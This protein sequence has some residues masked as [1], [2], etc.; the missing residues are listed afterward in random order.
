MEAKKAENRQGTLKSTG[1]YLLTSCD[2]SGA[3]HLAASENVI[4]FQIGKGQQLIESFSLAADDFPH[5]MRS[6]EKILAA[7]ACIDLF[8]H[9][10]ILL[11]LSTYY[12]KAEL[13]SHGSESDPTHEAPIRVQPPSLSR[14]TQPSSQAQPSPRFPQ[15]TPSSIQFPD[16]SPIQNT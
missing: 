1:C 4:S 10:Q 12:H 9:R 11:S 5:M 8:L 7:G 15:L 6:G 3:V 13:I 14:D 16:G 2:Y